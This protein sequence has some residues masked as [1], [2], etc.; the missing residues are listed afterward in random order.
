MNKGLRISDALSL[1]IDSVTDT[2]GVLAIKG[3][4]KSYVSMVLIEELIKQGLP[5]VA[6]DPVGVFFG[7]RSSVDGK[8]AGLPVIIVGGQHAD[9][10][11]EEGAGGVLADFLINERRSMVFDLSDLPTK[12]S[13]LRFAL[14]FFE[15]L[16]RGARREPIH[17]VIDEADEFCPQKPF[18][19]ETRLLRAV[20]VLVRRGRAKGL[21]V[22]LISQRPAVVSK[23]VL[24]QCSTLIVG[25]IT[26]PQDRKSVD[27]WVL[28]HGTAEQRQT[29]LASLASLPTKEKWVWAPQRD[30]FSRVMIRDRETFD[31]SATPR[32][33]EVRHEPKKL[34][35]VDL[36]ALRAQMAA[37][38]EKAK[39]DDPKELRRRIAELEKEK[40]AG[41]WS[42]PPIEVPPRTSRCAVC[43]KEDEAG[44]GMWACHVDLDTT[45]VHTGQCFA[46]YNAQKARHLGPSGSFVGPTARGGLESVQMDL[47]H[48]ASTIRGILEA[49]IAQED[50]RPPAPSAHRSTHIHYANGSLLATKLPPSGR[51]AKSD[52]LGLGERAILRAAAQHHDGVT[53]EQLTVLTGY[54]RSSRDTYLQ[55]LR[56]AALIEQHGETI[57][58]TRA[59]VTALGKDFE[60]LP[61][62]P[63]LRRYWLDR[64][65]EGERRILEIV[66]GAYPRAVPRD[67][68]SE[69][70]GYKRSSRDTYLQRLGARKLVEIVDRGAVRSS[71]LLHEAS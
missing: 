15:R 58:A 69:Q 38:I 52:G 26:S 59:G 25:R 27:E 3:A 57:L 45:P 20:E 46:R 50:Q 12:A 33:G 4:G 29:F 53:R 56:A 2:I 32:I 37:T 55:R 65:P 47:A 23:N 16:Y 9:L 21:G 35:P 40:L 43:H 17:V 1:P 34:A 64:L 28:A 63:E 39:A 61:K 10:P 18:G 66:C 5:V 24:T 7:L 54:R 62:G 70:T 30:V 11:L 13:T 8:T 6:L 71:T 41:V 31:S 22:T 48:A 60:P 42:G 67:R 49:S 19:E 14:D 51:V 36:D 44:L 68:L